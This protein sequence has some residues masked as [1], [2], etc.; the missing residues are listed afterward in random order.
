MG[1]EAMRTLTEEDHQT[2]DGSVDRRRVCIE[3]PG[4]TSGQ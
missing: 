3:P 2:F 4:L 1:A